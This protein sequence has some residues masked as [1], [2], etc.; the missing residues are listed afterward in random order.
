MVLHARLPGHP[1]WRCGHYQDTDL[2]SVYVRAG[3]PLTGAS[4]AS[5][6]AYQNRPY[7]AIYCGNFK[8][9]AEGKFDVEAVSQRQP[10]P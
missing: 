8:R 3:M 10:D 2:S 7:N 9:M 4:I 1:S 6:F 5:C